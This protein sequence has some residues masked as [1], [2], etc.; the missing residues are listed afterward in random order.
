[1][2][3]QPITPLSANWARQRCFYIDLLAVLLCATGT[4][5]RRQ[6]AG[7]DNLVSLESQLLLVGAL[8]GR[9]GQGHEAGTGRLEDAEGSDELQ[10]GVDSGRFGRTVTRQ[11][12]KKKKRRRKKETKGTNQNL[13]RKNLHFNDAADSTNIKHLAA[14]LVGKVGNRLEMLV[15][16]AERLGRRELAGV[17]VGRCALLQALLVLVDQVRV[18]GRGVGVAR[19]DLAVVRQELLKV[20]GAEDVDLGEEQLALNKGGARV[21]E[22]GPDGDEVLELAAGLLDDTVLARQHNGH[23]RE[24]L[25]L[26]VA[27]DE[28]VNVEAAGGENARQAGQNARLVLD[29]AVEDVTLG[30]CH[31]RGGR[32]VEDVGDGGLG[33]PGRGRLSERERRRPAAEGL[34]GNGRGRRGAGRVVADG[35][36]REGAAGGGCPAQRRSQGSQRGHCLSYFSISVAGYRETRKVKKERRK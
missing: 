15:L 22:H 7:V 24:V 11:V 27:D 3:I 8:E 18:G 17:K 13:D 5:T 21:V 25:D 33:G 10:E 16:V 26:G 6:L 29:K 32:L 9:S 12:S 36:G 19:R 14:K 1:M 20:L 28:R 4:L 2:K 35:A 31:G 30:G 34:V 23:A